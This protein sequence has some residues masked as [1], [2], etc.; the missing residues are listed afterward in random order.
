MTVGL[1]WPVAPDLPVTQ[2]FHRSALA[3]EPRGYVER[4]DGPWRFRR[5]AFGGAELVDHF[6][7]GVD[8][9]CPIGTTIVA[10]EA[11]RIVAA[12]TYSSTGEHY[13]MLQVRLGTVLFFTHL[14]AGG[15][16]VR[17]GQHVVRGQR[18]ALS[19]NSG[20]STGPHLHWEVRKGSPADD[21][22]LSGAWFR[23][24]PERLRVG[25]DRAGAEWITPP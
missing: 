14:K 19:G 3:V 10:P 18:L 13:L 11:G 8:I 5:L 21:P 24:N 4:D 7:P 16:L 25:G 17:V 1:R 20:M 23:F 2:P 9:A 22:H 6:H 15:L 12:G